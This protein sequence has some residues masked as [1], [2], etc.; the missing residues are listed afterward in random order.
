MMRG[1]QPMS[2]RMH[3]SG[4]L[5]NQLFQWAYAHVLAAKYG[6]TILPIYDNLHNPGVAPSED[7]LNTICSHWRT[8]EK[9]N[10]FGLLLSCLDKIGFEN[11]THSIICRILNLSRT[12]N[13]YDLPSISTKAPRL[14]TGY[15]QNVKSL[16]GIS[17][18]LFQE[19]SEKVTSINPPMNMPLNYQVLHV[20]RG[21]FNQYSQSY[22]L[23]GP[24]FYEDNLIKDQPKVLC[25]DSVG[26]SE[27][28]I[29]RIKPE[30]V[31]GPNETSA[32]QV[33]RIMMDATHVVMSNS[34][35]SWWGGFLAAK[36]GSSV[37]Q[38]RPF[39]K[40]VKTYVDQLEYSEFL[41][42]QANFLEV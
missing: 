42:R 1:K 33:L 36:S 40:C 14:V 9:R 5:G 37:V 11:R 39:Y 25:T 21:D 18:L 24:E 38:P 10:Y 30:V 17:D 19:L 35:L 34:T 8:P 28:I 27:E 22:G 3:V 7:L 12:Q 41:Q 20:R 13:S 6:Q 29:S 26:G 15:F 2:V 4:R 31:L 23:L 16:E 32:W